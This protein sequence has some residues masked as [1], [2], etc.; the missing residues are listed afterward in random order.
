M[1]IRMGICQ[2]VSGLGYQGKHFVVLF[3][4]DIQQEALYHF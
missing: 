1:P 3:V 2:A 4:F